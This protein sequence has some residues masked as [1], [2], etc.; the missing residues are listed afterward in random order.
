MNPG[1]VAAE[2]PPN[3]PRQPGV[4]DGATLVPREDRK[5]ATDERQAVHEVFDRDRADAQAQLVGLA[6][7]HDGASGQ[8]AVEDARER[9]DHQ[10]EG[11]RPWRCQ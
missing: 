11:P 4:I 7:V 1:A 8:V 2:P 6:V 10:A 3:D 5:H 9:D